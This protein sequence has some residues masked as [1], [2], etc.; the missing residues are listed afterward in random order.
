MKRMLSALLALSALAGCVG[1]P[2]P[3]TMQMLANA[4]A[5][6]AMGDQAQC[7]SIPTIQIQANLEAQEAAQIKNAQAAAA[8][9]VLLGAAALGVAASDGGYH[10]G[11]HHPHYNHWH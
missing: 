1:Q 6:C 3:L 4:Q 2:S 8:L 5:A 9:A 10:G 11:Y 7:A